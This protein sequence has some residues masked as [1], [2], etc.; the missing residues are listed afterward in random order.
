LWR[1]SSTFPDSHVE[2][3]WYSFIL[4]TKNCR[5]Y[6]SEIA[7]ILRPFVLYNSYLPQICKDLNDRC[8]SEE[9]THRFSISERYM[10]QM[11]ALPL[12]VLRSHRVNN[13]S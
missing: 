1:L 3:T 6:R 7:N 9:D 12:H 8:I 4:S 13:C 10:L 11:F 2:T 5:T